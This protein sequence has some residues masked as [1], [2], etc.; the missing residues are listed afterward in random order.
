MGFRENLITDWKDK[1]I[2]YQEK[3]FYIL[4]LLGGT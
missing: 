1:T 4:A 2:E 3:K